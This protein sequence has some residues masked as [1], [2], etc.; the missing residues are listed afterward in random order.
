MIHLFLI[1]QSFNRGMV[2]ETM[3]QRRIA[4]ILIEHCNEF[5]PDLQETM[6]PS[7][8]SVSPPLTYTCTSPT[9]SQGSTSLQSYTKTSDSYTALSHDSHDSSKLSPELPHPLAD[10][11]QDE[12]VTVNMVDGCNSPKVYHRNFSSPGPTDS[13]KPTAKPV[14]PPV[15]PRTSSSNSL[16]PPESPSFSH[17]SVNPPSPAPRV[18]FSGSSSVAARTSGGD[19]SVGE[20]LMHEDENSGS[21]GKSE[22]NHQHLPSVAH[23]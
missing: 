11:A 12:G 7:K 19:P 2:T 15:M 5:F 22:D 10:S 23:R 1:Y 18:K 14:P 20:R 13:F 8:P 3:L 4:E 21:S 16:T 9:S 6:S 17:R